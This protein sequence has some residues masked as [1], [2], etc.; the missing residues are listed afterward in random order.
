MLIVY[1]MLLS[2]RMHGGTRAHTNTH[3]SA[4]ACARQKN[5]ILIQISRGLSSGDAVDVRLHAKVI[6]LHADL[7]SR[8]LARMLILGLIS[9]TRVSS[10]A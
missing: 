5:E 4:C 1:E 6:G 8:Q 3:T 2:I 10:G 9:R 7:D